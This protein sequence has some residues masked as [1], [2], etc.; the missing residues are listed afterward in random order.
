MSASF[1][2]TNKSDWSRFLL[3]QIL[4]S[5]CVPCASIGNHLK[6][7]R[8]CAVPAPKLL[9][10]SA[11]SCRSTGDVL[12]RYC[13]KRRAWRGPIPGKCSNRSV[14]FSIGFIPTYFTFFLVILLKPVVGGAKGAKIGLFK[15][16]EGRALVIK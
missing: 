12:K 16:L 6:H 3:A 11:S 15:R 9:I 7:R 13:T 8:H 4:H 10:A 2:T 14:S 5:S 1:S